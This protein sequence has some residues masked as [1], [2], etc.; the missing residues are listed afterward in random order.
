[1]RISWNTGVAEGWEG[2]RLCKSSCIA[3]PNPDGEQ[4]WQFLPAPPA[5]ART[6]AAITEHC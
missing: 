5:G 3:V 1:M 2:S 4:G 6:A